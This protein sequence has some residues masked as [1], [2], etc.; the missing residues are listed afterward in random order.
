M[1]DNNYILRNDIYAMQPQKPIDYIIGDL[2][3][4]SSLNVFYGEAG[5][6]KTYSALS[7]AVAVANGKDWLGFTTKK[8]PVLIIDEESGEK[9]LSRRLNE[10]IR[11][12]DCDGSGQLYF[13]SLGGFKLDNKEDVKNIE[14]EIERLG[15]KLIIFDALADIMDG[16]ENSKKEVQ[17]VMNNLRKIADNTDSSIILIHHA[18]K[19]GGYR[20]SSAIKASSDLL[21]QISSDADDSIINFKI[22]KN[23]D[24]SSATWTAEAIWEDDIFYLQ[25]I[26]PVQKSSVRED[27]VLNYL[28]ENGESSLSSIMK[29][30]TG[31]APSGAKKAVYALLDLGTIYRTNPEAGNRGAKYK[32]VEN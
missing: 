21:V 7:M 22:E 25:S 20:G 3:T 13:I 29:N 9:R 32:L 4:N 6:K 2:I 31:C 27:Y 24:G 15:I 5:S 16:D 28:K 17:P 10:T 26:S 8:S 18:N 14:S 11:G 30:A 12:A 23:R 19:T 1:P